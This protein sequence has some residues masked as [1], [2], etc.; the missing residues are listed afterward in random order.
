MV[1]ASQPDAV[2][3]FG[4]APRF[5]S[6]RTFS[7]SGAAI[8]SSVVP[9]FVW[10]LASRPASSSADNCRG[11]PN[12]AVYIQ[13]AAPDTPT[14]AGAA[15]AASGGAANSAITDQQLPAYDRYSSFSYGKPVVK[16]S[17]LT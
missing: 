10:L 4:L 16:Y 13:G 1:R 11:E 3:A 6:R 12:R 15:G 17:G 7:A 9:F 8:I 2:R 5:K 14:V